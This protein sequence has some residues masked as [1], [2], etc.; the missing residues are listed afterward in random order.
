MTDSLNKKPIHKTVTKKTW[1]K[2]VLIVTFVLINIIVIAA[3]AIAEFGNS[4]NAA[5]LSEV[6]LRWWFLLPAA[7][8]FFFALTAEI[9]K[10]IMMMREMSSKE[11]FDYKKSV[12][13]ARRTVLLGKYYDNITPA[14]VGG[15]PFQ[16]YYM[17]KN[18]GLPNGASTAIPIFGMISGQIGFMIIATACFLVG[19]FTIN[20]APLIATACFGLLFYGFWPVVVM[21]ATFLPKA[22][23]ELIVLFVKLLAKIKIVKDQK[24]TIE[25][26]GV[27][28][29][30]YAKSIKLILKKKGLFAKT[31]LLSV[32]FNSL[33][34]AIPFFV[35]TAFGGDVDF[36]PCFVTTVAVT[37]AVYFVPTPGNSGAAE[38]TFFMVF[39]ALSTGYIF[40]AMLVWRF[41]SYYIYIIMGPIIYYFMHREKKLEQKNATKKA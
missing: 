35:L 33:V 6:R 14:A 32:V 23:T 39:S 40:W 18:S 27:E 28:V 41:F 17:R 15:Q 1:R 37:S 20:N 8:C 9:H 16:I 12:K 5:E 7:L 25:K 4:E 11:S 30:E 26:I 19:S 10:Y 21:I 36:L 3:T 31:I 22:T 13:V 34:A 24:K 38:G 29:G 2:P